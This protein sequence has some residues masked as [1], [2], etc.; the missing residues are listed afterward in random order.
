ME[1]SKSFVRAKMQFKG[2]WVDT[3]SSLVIPLDRENLSIARDFVYNQKDKLYTLEIK[4]YREQRSLDANAYLWVL[5]QKI[6]EAVK[7]T[8]ELVYQK[9]IKDVGQFVIVPIKDEATAQWI[10]NWQYKGLGWV[11]EVIGDSKI[12]GYKN[13]ICYYGSS[14]YDTKEMSILIDSVVTECKDL[15]IETL[16]PIELERMKCEWVK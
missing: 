2:A 1:K 15:G 5:C 14:T 16:S 11:C 7:T 10:K 4:E 6:A 12:Q 9:L 3:S 13:V 8:K